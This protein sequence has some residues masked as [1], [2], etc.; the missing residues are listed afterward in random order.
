MEFFFC[1]QIE[2][3]NFFLD[4]EESHHL[5]KVLRHA[6]GDELM[7]TDGKGK[8]IRAKIIQEHK[9]S[10]ELQTIEVVKVEPQPSPTIHIAIAPTKNIDRFEWFLEKATEIGITEITP[11]ICTRSERNKIKHERLEKILVG[12]M[13][14]SLRLW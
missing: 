13:K 14:Q 7:V 2:T 8:L 4:E 3:D 10:G 1:S 12:A 9:K 6:V 11:I 5:F